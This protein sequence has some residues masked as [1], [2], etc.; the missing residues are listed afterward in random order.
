MIA[1]LPSGRAYESE[2]NRGTGLIAGLLARR[3]ESSLEIVA[4]STA[5]RTVE[6]IAIAS[7]Q[8]RIDVRFERS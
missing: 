3:T 8:S 4:A 6:S 7:R 1:A 2:S 5:Y